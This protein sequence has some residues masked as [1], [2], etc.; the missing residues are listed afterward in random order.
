MLHW[1][2]GLDGIQPGS[3]FLSNASLSKAGGA[4][5]STHPLGRCGA[6]ARVLSPSPPQPGY[7]RWP[8]RSETQLNYRCRTRSRRSRLSL[9]KRRVSLLPQNHS[10]LRQG[11]INRLLRQ[12]RHDR[13]SSFVRMQPVVG[14]VPLE[15]AFI[16][17]HR[18]EIVEVD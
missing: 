11:L 13:V 3:C 5:V 14:E 17:H 18:A 1:K 6:D 16:V 10:R 8:R 4:G 7:A 9:N 12:R 2:G 15:Q